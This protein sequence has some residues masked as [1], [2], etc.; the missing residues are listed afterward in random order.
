MTEIYSSTQRNRDELYHFLLFLATER[1]VIAMPTLI[2]AIEL[3]GD[4]DTWEIDFLNLRGLAD[5][6]IKLVDR[7]QA[8]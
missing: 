6:K 8:R 5:K 3:L 4:F 1:K 7:R 2:E